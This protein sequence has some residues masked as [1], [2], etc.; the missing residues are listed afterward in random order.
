MVL[1][2]QEEVEV[3]FLLQGRENTNKFQAAKK[4]IERKY[5]IKKVDTAIISKIC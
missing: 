5:S 1:S 4:V 2:S 3:M